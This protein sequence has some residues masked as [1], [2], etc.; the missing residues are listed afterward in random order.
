MHCITLSAI[1][2]GVQAALREGKCGYSK[3]NRLAALM[4]LAVH[5]LA[6]D[7]AALALALAEGVLMEVAGDDA[8]I[9]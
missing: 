7:D 1:D 9:S 3:T 5:L 6:Y 8:A 4:L 2:K